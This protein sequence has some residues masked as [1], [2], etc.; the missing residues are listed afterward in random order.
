MKSVMKQMFLSED[1]MHNNY[2]Q[3]YDLRQRE[4]SVAEFTREFEHLM[5]KCDIS[6]PDE[7]TIARYLRG[8]RVEITDAVV[9]LPYWTYTEVKR[10]AIKVEKQRGHK[11]GYQTPTSSSSNT[12]P[13]SNSKKVEVPREQ[14]NSSKTFQRPINKPEGKKCFKCQ[15]LGHIA[16]D[17]PNRRVITILEGE[18]TAYVEYSE[19]EVKESTEVEE[20]LHT[21]EGESLV[22]QRCLQTTIGTED[23]WVR[24]CIFFTKC[25]TQG[26]VCKVIIDGG[27]CTNVV[28]LTMVQKLGLP[29]E[30]HPHPYNL[31]WFQKGKSTRVE[32][33]CL[34]EFS[35]G[36]TYSDTV[37]CDVVPMDACHILLGRPWQY[38]RKVSHD[39]FRNTYSFS[40]DGRKIVLAPMKMKPDAEKEN[41]K[42]N[43]GVF[44][45]GSQIMREAE[46]EQNLYALVVVER[47]SEKNDGDGMPSHPLLHPILEKFSDVIPSEIPPGLPPKRSI[48]HCIDL[49]PGASLPNK[50]AYRMNPSQSAELQRQ[51][52]E[53]LAKG[54]VRES[55]SPCAVPALLVPKKDGSWRMCVDSRAINKITIKYHFPIPRLDDMLDQLYGASVFSKIDLRSGYHQIRMREGDEWKTAFKT[56]Q[57]LYEWLVM[58]FRLSNAPSTFMRLM[59]EIFRPFM[60]KFLVVYFD[61][62]LI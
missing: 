60:G 19:E 57:G 52:E 26:K 11:P 44:L 48:Q 46:M 23:S 55:M 10:L 18:E 20:I 30:T 54:V 14:A 31:Q 13:P 2:L 4:K 22:I 47:G 58:S 41:E 61:D 9:L 1:Y 51:V 25:T 16:T 56:G 32:K 5:L 43:G 7:Q 33:R 39:G 59:K 45:T 37:W 28:A 3:L 17:C 36:K 8:L 49:V 21:D 38:D 29:T 53:L 50:A 6:E 24:E 34:V 35:I 15:G 40:K 27:S 42:G 12:T 62:I